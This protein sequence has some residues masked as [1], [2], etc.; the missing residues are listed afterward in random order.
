[1][2]VG[3][4]GVRAAGLK[5]HAVVL[6]SGVLQSQP[7]L[8]GTK[9]ELGEYAT[10][11]SGLAQGEYTVELVNL[12]ELKVNLAPGQFILVEFRYDFVNPP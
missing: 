12:A 9:V 10:E 2:G 7:Q 8:T 3:V 4:I 5:D 1:M 6:H 11:F